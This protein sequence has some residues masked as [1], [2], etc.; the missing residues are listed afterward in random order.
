MSRLESLFSKQFI[1]IL[2]CYRL[3]I[4]FN[5]VFYQSV[6]YTLSGPSVSKHV[7]E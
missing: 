5:I 6:G 7:H 1:D 3:I 4:F 2:I